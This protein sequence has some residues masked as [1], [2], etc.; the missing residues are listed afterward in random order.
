M[1]RAVLDSS[2]LVSAFLTPKG[3]SA[4]LIELARRGAFEFCLSREIVAET[5]GVLVAKR[6]RLSRWYRYQDDRIARFRQLLST[7]AVIVGPLPDLEVVPDDSADNK[8]VATGLAGGATVIVAGDRHLLDLGRYGDI[9]I[10]T[11]R[12]FLDELC[13][14]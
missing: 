13:Q 8:I 9:R 7:L 3:T 14:P 12:L 4:T 10:L 6:E 2:V 11:P 1:V 5:V